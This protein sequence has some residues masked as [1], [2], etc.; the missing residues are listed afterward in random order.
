M[1]V[2]KRNQMEEAIS[3]TLDQGPRPTAA[4]QTKLKR[5]LDTDRT[6]TDTPRSNPARSKYAFYSGEAPGRGSE[7]RFTTYEVFALLEA[8]NLMEH[9]MPQATVVSVLRQGR[10]VLEARHAEILQ[11]D[12]VTLFNTK[13]IRESLGPGSIAV[14]STRPVFLLLVTRPP[15]KGRSSNQRIEVEVL[16]EKEIGF[17]RWPA[18][19]SMTMIELSYTAHA[20]REALAK[21]KPS[22]RG[23]GS[24]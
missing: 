15:K 10:K 4:L 24:A 13:K 2:W 16:E 11:W 3:L 18:G 20:L 17:S 8:Y 9:G 5:L 7:V 6:L 22:K 23:R 21:T 1:D 12:P 14:S 19:T